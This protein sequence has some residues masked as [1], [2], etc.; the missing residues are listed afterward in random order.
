LARAAQQA[1]VRTAVRDDAQVLRRRTAQRPDE[2]HGL[3]P[4]TPAA[5]A[6]GHPVL[7]LAGD[8]VDGDALVGDHSLLDSD[9]VADRRRA[10]VHPVQRWRVRMPARWTSFASTTRP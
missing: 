6:D 3:A 4:R 1:D 10:G 9:G 5:D 7:H 8:L 2:G